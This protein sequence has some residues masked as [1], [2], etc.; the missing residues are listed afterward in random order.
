[1]MFNKPKPVAQSYTLRATGT[2][3]GGGRYMYGEK[4]DKSVRWSAEYG[5]YDEAREIGELLCATPAFDTF[6][7]TYG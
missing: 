5:T 4:M 7:A 1:M 6:T 2:T 3:P